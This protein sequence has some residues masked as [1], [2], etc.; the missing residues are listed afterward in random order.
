MAAETVTKSMQPASQFY[1]VIFRRQ[2]VKLSGLKF[3]REGIPKQ[4]NIIHFILHAVSKLELLVFHTHKKQTNELYKQEK[5]KWE[6]RIL[7]AVLADVR[8]LQ[9]QTITLDSGFLFPPIPL[10]QCCFAGW[11]KIERKVDIIGATLKEGKRGRAF[12]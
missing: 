3:Y 10:A 9:S 11:K 12:F 1:S 5:S 6:V 8:V 2:N 7:A 4:Q